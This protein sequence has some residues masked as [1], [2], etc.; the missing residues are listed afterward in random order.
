LDD[1]DF[2]PIVIRHCP[3]KSKRG[4]ATPKQ[5]VDLIKQRYKEA[6]ELARDEQEKW[7]GH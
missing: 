1:E 6:K 7:D 3:Q 4:I 2:E 5:N